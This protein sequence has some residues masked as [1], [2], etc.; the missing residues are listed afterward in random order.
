[1]KENSNILFLKQEDMIKA[2]V[3]DMKLCLSDVEKTLT[4]LSDNKIINPSKTSM[5]V[6][7]NDGSYHFKLNSMPSYIGGDINRPGI[8]WAGESPLNIKTKLNPMGIDIMILSDA[9]T[10]L[11]VAIMDA[12]LI[13]AMRTSACTVT[14]VKHLIAGNAKEVTVIG[15]GI[16]GRT[17]LM[18]LR[19]SGLKFSKIRLCDLYKEKAQILADEFKNELNITVT[20]DTEAACWNT[21]IVIS[22]TTAKKQVVNEEWLNKCTLG[23][24][25][26]MN[27]FPTEAITGADVLVVDNWD[28]LNGYTASSFAK[29][30][31]EGLIKKETTLELPDLVAGKVKGR[32]NDN[33]R[34]MYIA[35]GLACLDVMMGDRIYKYADE[36]NI[37]QQLSLWDSPIWV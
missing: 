28:Q 4:L 5:M 26:G 7:K 11:P 35:R 34:I 6:Y 1:M 31:E 10:V 30:S 33:Q 9:D 37:G 21:D 12:T 27:E 36:M 17:M 29:L 20:D 22:A 32:N 15:A 13:T 23:C 25:C 3:L 2:G 8:K 24:Q 19:D 18:A 14:A 16:I